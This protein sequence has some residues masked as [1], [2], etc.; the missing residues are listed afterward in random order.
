MF[1]S[2]ING[3][4]KN[5]V[6][7]YIAKLKA[8]YEASIMEEKLKVIE[9]ERKLLDCKKYVADIEK[10]QK[11]IVNVLETYKKFQDE[12]NKNLEL[13][14]SEQFNLV[15]QHILTFFDEL[16]NKYPGI[17]HNNSYKELLEDISKILRQN[18]ENKEQIVKN[19]V[20]ENDSMR[21]LLNKMQ[22]YRKEKEP[23][24]NVKEVYIERAGKNMIKP[25]TD[26]EL[27]ESENYDNLVDKFLDTKPEENE[28][29]M[30]IQSSGFDLKE[31]ISPTMSLS[32]IMKA[33]DFYNG[34]GQGE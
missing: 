30:K 17:E 32:E 18:K 13:L 34:D 29:T 4:D 1:S 28:R 21:I 26:M 5:E 24:T 7:K 2:E 9:S 31:A 19:T 6:D 20:S 11:N 23:E 22:Q 12:G 25:V 27:D 8:E 3:Y 14:R 10:K 16:K 33:F 15:Y